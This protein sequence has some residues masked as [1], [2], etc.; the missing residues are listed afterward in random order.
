MRGRPRLCAFRLPLSSMLRHCGRLAIT[1]QRV[2]RH[3][4]AR[5]PAVR[6]ISKSAGIVGLANVGKSC[7]FNA[8]T[9]TQRAQSANYPFCTIK[10]NSSQVAVEDPRLRQL[11]A[12]AG[13]AA[14]RPA[15]GQRMR[16]A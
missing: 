14:V 12:I 1:Q 9:R 4:A 7:L 15:Q 16:R 6:S 3:G 13:S 5:L 2:A 10:P 11:A 8:L